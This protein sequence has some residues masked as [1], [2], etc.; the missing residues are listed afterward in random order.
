VRSSWRTDAQSPSVSWDQSRGPIGIGPVRGEASS[1]EPLFE[2]R[3]CI[4]ER[5][6]REEADCGSGCPGDES[7]ASA[8]EQEA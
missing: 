4:Q 1:Q 6:Q 3:L 2:P 5:G 7:D 8:E